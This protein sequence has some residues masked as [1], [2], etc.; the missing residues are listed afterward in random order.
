MYEECISFCH[1]LCACLGEQFILQICI[2]KIDSS[3]NERKGR[4]YLAV[5][6]GTQKPFYLDKVAHAAE[7]TVSIKPISFNR[8]LLLLIAIET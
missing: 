6:R 7:G 8:N 5:L 4:P 2:G 3:K 1:E